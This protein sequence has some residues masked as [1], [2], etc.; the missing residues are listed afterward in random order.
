VN[1]LFGDCHAGTV[2]PVEAYNSFH[3]PGT[4]TTV[5]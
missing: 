4:D 3:N 1:L 5:P 2:T